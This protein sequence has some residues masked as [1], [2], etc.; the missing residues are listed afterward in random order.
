VFERESYWERYESLIGNDTRER[1]REREG[2]RD[3]EREILEY[4]WERCLPSGSGIRKSTNYEKRL[5]FVIVLTKLN[6]YGSRKST[7]YEKRLNFVKVLTKLKRYTSHGQ[8]GLSNT[9][10][11][12]LVYAGGMRINHELH[13]RAST[14]Q[15]DSDRESERERERERERVYKERYTIMI[16]NTTNVAQPEP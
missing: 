6:R 13:T 12:R 15:T 10:R 8:R 14:L 7:N 11:E 3:R 16:R 9:K 5:N 1:E 4:D 2:E